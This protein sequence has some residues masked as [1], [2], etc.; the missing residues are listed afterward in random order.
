MDKVNSTTDSITLTELEKHIR[1]QST[2]E[3][4]DNKSL[5][6]GLQIPSGW[7]DAHPSSTV[8]THVATPP[9]GADVQQSALH[10][11]A[12]IHIPEPI[13]APLS[14]AVAAVK[15][16]A[17]APLS[18]A[19]AA[20]LAPAPGPLSTAVAAV[21]VPTPHSAHTPATQTTTSLNAAA[22]HVQKPTSHI[23]TS[24][25]KTLAHHT[26]ATVQTPVQTTVKASGGTSVS[27]SALPVDVIGAPDP[28][29]FNFDF[30]V[31]TGDVEYLFD[32]E[33]NVD[34]DFGGLGLGF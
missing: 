34:Y 31:S 4:S 15:V 26:T 14:T 17:P 29:F 11:T 7:V 32:F 23:L 3:N 9:G 25:A 30:S 18:T 10:T 21:L 22:S 20:V 33:L 24:D 19:V 6:C 13:P 27:K 1:D 12:A 28:V 8:Q 2:S 5:G 16:P